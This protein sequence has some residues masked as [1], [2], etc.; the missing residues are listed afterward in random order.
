MKKPKDFFERYA[1]QVS[2]HEIGV[3]GQEKLARG[4]V[5]LVGVGGLGSVA[6]LYL[7]AA[8]VRTLG[9][10]DGDKLELSNLQRQ[11]AYNTEDVGSLKTQ[12]AGRT[13]SALNPHVEIVIHEGR[14]TRGNA[15]DIVAQ[16]GFVIDATDNFESKFL[17]ADTCHRLQKPYS[18][19]GI[20][21]FGGQAMTVLPGKTACYRCVFGAPPPADGALPRGPLGAV[22]GVVGSVQATEALKWMLRCGHL[23]TNR[24][25]T[26]DALEMTCRIVA[27]SRD[28]QCPLCGERAHVQRGKVTRRKR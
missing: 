20:A 9:L 24:I 27:I 21:G 11:I 26:Y 8:G 5:L 16:Y 1:R 18:H 10:I 2:L 17:I 4:R 25:L 22:P 12:A 7:A 28:R 15:G 23:L 19:G 13:F 6:G 14:L 3:S